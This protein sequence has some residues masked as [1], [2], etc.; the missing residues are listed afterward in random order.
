M[1]WPGWCWGRRG[2]SHRADGDGSDR[3]RRLDVT[4]LSLRGRGV[5]VRLSFEGSVVLF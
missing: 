3:S 2:W 5:V 4:A 1:Q